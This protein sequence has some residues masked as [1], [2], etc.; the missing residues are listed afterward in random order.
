MA[1]SLPDALPKAL[2]FPD[3]V[4][5]SRGVEQIRHAMEVDKFHL[6]RW[7]DRARGGRGRLEAEVR[8][9]RD[10]LE[11]GRADRAHLAA[12]AEQHGDLPEPS[13]FRT[14]FGFHDPMNVWRHEARLER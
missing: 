9:M 10:D 3:A 14:S 7:V 11:R 2:A 6:W 8:Q 1:L 13:P 4:L 5:M 12:L